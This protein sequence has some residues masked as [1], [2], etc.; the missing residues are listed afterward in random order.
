MYNGARYFEPPTGRFPQSDPMG[1]FG[2][3]IS[4]YVYG[5]NN[6]LSN[7]DPSGMD[8]TQC[9]Y[10]PA[11]CGMAGNLPAAVPVPQVLVDYSAGL[12]DGASFGVTS[13]IRDA[14]GTNDQVDECSIAYRL[15][16]WSSFA[17]GAGRLAY[18]GLAKAG[19]E[20]A[21]SGLEASAFRS[22]LRKAFGGG[23]SFRPPNLSKYATDDA[24]RAAAGRTNPLGNALG[25]GAAAT[26]A[27]EGSGAKCGCQK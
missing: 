6:P 26:G 1:L 20:A 13:L 3:Q 9:M 8:D 10:D 16:G 23:N 4:T 17:L 24:L 22:G 7:I 2:G 14:M 15:G 18:A 25:A 11:S 21:A 5:N 19:A 12:G 27:Y